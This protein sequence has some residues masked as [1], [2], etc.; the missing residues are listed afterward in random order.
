MKKQR[1]IFLLIFLAIFQNQIIAQFSKQQAIDLVL[2]QILINELGTIN[3]YISDNTKSKQN[4]IQLG[5][6]TS[7]NLPY[8]NNWICFVDDIPYAN[9]AH[10]CRYI[11]IDAATGS[12][13]IVNKK[14]FPPDLNTAYNSIALMPQPTPIDLPINPNSVFNGTDPNPNLYAVIICGAR[15]GLYH[16]YFRDISAIY[17]TLIDIYG[18]TKDNIFVHYDGVSSYFGADLDGPDVLSNDI[19]YGVTKDEVLHTF[20][21]MAGDSDTSPEIP[22]LGPKDQLFIFVTDH[23]YIDE[24]NGHSYLYLPDHDNYNDDL[25]DFEMAD[26]L[27]GIN[28]SQIIAVFE[29][30]Y[31]GGFKT[32]LS[33]YTNYNVQ[34]ENRAIHTASNE[35]SS[36]AEFWFTRYNYDEFVYYWTYESIL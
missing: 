5:D 2:N 13:Q 33:D 4:D 36:I 27:S 22:E 3:V 25:A 19:D 6:K 35:E 21:E 9:W 24:D 15:D 16:R 34:C 30:C 11:L 23:G 26:A 20:S 28:C 12:Y 10:A 17:C 1:I 32:E 18:Y 29:P 8:S 14:F 7:V 31:I